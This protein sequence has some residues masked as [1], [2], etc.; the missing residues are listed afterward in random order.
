MQLLEE[1]LA[2]KE[3]FRAMDLQKQLLYSLADQVELG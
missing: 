2:A 1:E 3:D